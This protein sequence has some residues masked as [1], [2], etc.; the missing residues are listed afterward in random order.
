MEAVEGQKYQLQP[1]SGLPVT[2]FRL[3]IKKTFTEQTV[4]LADNYY[5]EVWEIH[6]RIIQRPPDYV[7][8]IVAVDKRDVEL[9]R[10]KRT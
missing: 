8:D 4:Q 3:K 5:L 1:N 7:V 6:G 2:S 10:I 9:G